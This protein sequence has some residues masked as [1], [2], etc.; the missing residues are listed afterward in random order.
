MLCMLTKMIHKYTTEV[1]N[2]FINPEFIIFRP[3]IISWKLFNVGSKIGLFSGLFFNV[4]PPKDIV[5][6]HLPS[7][8]FQSSY[9]LQ[10]MTP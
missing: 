9:T 6:G 8:I 3:K 1:Q 7:P 2:E 4:G 5:P 10:T